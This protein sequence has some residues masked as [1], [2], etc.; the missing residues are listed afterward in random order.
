QRVQ[1]FPRRRIMSRL[2]FISLFLSLPALAAEELEAIQVEAK[3]ES[4]AY[5]FGASTQITPND[6]ERKPLPLL[7]NQLESV[8]GLTALQSGGPGGQT[9]Y[10]MRGAEAR[11]LSFTLDS[12]RLNDTSNDARTYDAAFLTSPFIAE[13]HV[14]KGPQAVLFGSDALGGLIDL[15]S[16][17]GESA[18]ETR[19]NVMGGSFGTVQGTIGHDWKTADHQGTFTITQFHTD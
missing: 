4:E 1:T 11:H 10:F 16:R 9:S 5:T 12:L 17:K 19:V 3:K 13:I 7:T 15:R 8:P 2:V 6:M 18:P 14:F